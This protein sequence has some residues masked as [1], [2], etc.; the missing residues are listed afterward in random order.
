MK[1]LIFI[2]VLVVVIGTCFTVSPFADFYVIPIKTNKVEI[3]S[4]IV[5]KTGQTDCWD[6]AAESDPG[7]RHLSACSS[8]L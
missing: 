5:P 2:S 4:T 8:A 6:S 3:T 7:Y 1:K